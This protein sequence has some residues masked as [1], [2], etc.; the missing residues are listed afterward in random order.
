MAAESPLPPSASPLSATLL[1]SGYPVK[2]AIPDHFGNRLSAKL[3]A[4]PISFDLVRRH[5]KSII[6]MTAK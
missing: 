6:S 5:Q 1:D 2:T 3:R 4:I